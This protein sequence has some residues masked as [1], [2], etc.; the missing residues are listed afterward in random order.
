MPRSMLGERALV[1]GA[2][3]RGCGA[4]RCVL[5]VRHPARRSP[6]SAASCRPRGWRAV[7]NAGRAVSLTLTFFLPRK[8]ASFWI[9]VLHRLVDLGMRV[10]EHH[11]DLEFAQAL[12]LRRAAG[13]ASRPRPSISSGPAMA[14]SAIS[15]SSA[16][17]ASG[18][19][20]AMSAPGEAQSPAAWPLAADDAVGRLVAEHAAIMRGIADRASR[21][22]CRPRCRSGRRPAPPPSRPTS[23]RAS[24]SGPRDCWSCRRSSL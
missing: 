15:R 19:T 22:R 17:R 16:P 18:P 7:S 8:S 14:S 21:C 2:E 12:L 10:V 23:R 4:P 11:R 3:T 1:V 6:R 9:C 13:R 24:A 5:L 20:T